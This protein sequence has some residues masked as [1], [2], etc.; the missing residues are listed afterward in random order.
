MS[1]ERASYKLVSMSVG[2][3]AGCCVAGTFESYMILIAVGS[4]VVTDLFLEVRS[5]RT[6]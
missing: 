4:W 6:G 1:I 3:A 2:A 5:R